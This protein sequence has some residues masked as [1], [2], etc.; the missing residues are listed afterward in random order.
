MDQLSL[1]DHVKAVYAEQDGTVDNETLYCKVAEKAG[2]SRAQLASKSLIGSGKSQA[3]RSTLERQIRWHQQTM[4]AAGW[5]EKTD[6]RGVWTLTKTGKMQLKKIGNH[7]T[8]IAFSTKLGVALWSYCRNAFAD[9]NEP[10]S[11]CLTSPPYPIQK[12]RAYGKV[13]LSEYSDFICQSLEPIV[14]HLQPGG[15]IALNV[16]N[17]IFL[18]GMPARS[19]YLERLTIKLAD[20]LSLYLMDRLVWLS[21]KPPGPVYWASINRVQLNAGYEP[22]LWFTNDPNRVFSDNNRV[23]EPHTES[24]L[25]LVESGGES[26]SSV[27]SDGAYRIRPGSYSN[28]TQ[29]KIPRNAFKYAN[30]CQSQRDYKATAR[31]LNLPAHGAPMPLALAEFLIGFLTPEESEA[32]VV[33]PFGG[34]LTT[35][36]AAEKL[37]RRWASSELYWEY[38]RGGATRFSHFK[39]FQMNSTFLD[40]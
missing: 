33:D 40:A 6:Q 16:S 35:A 1:F 26:R 28:S 15:S 22:I 4:K 34:S 24:H 11:L 37:G 12:P 25:K 27:N 39:S 38:I 21:N 32:L 3:Q 17:D 13:D 29:G 5:L 18:K 8:L 23:L 31:S 14:K 20:E 9:I 36:L 2:I 10:I 30:T 7:T 19:L